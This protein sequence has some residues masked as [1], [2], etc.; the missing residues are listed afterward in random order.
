MLASEQKK[1]LERQTQAWG[2]R[3]AR[4]GLRLNV[5]K[6]EYMTTNLD[7]PPTIRVDGNDL[8][9]TDYFKYLGSTLSADVNLAHEVVARKRCANEVALDD[10]SAVRQKYPGSLQVKG[11]SR[12]R[13][14]RGTVC[15]R[16]L[17]SHQRR[18]TLTKCNGD[19]DVTMDGRYHACRPHPVRR[20]ES[21][22]ALHQLPTNLV[23][24]TLDGTATFRAPT[25][26]MQSRSRSRNTR[27]TTTRTAE[28]TV[29]RHTACRP[30]A[31]GRS[32]RPGT[33]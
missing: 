2:E 14:I 29:A 12:S 11:L 16:M 32:L 26:T 21:G 9:R 28:A 8:C 5:K 22:S 7:K 13:S 15:C 27:K 30:E 33:R 18:R 10:W 6:T 31:C 25:K 24:S 23:K 3:L 17:I 1:G 20:S 19:E 4:F